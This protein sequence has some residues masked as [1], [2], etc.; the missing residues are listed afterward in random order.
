MA[1][2]L[3]AGGQARQ[4]RERDE[5]AQEHQ[6]GDR[7][8]SGGCEVQDQCRAFCI[9]SSCLRTPATRMGA[10]GFPEVRGGRSPVCRALRHSPR[11]RSGPDI[12]GPRCRSHRQQPTRYRAHSWTPNP[13]PLT[14]PAGPRHGAVLPGAGSMARPVPREFRRRRS[15]SN[16]VL[17]LAGPPPPSACL[18]ERVPA[19]SDCR[20]RRIPRSSVPGRPARF[21]LNPADKDPSGLGRPGRPG[22]A[23]PAKAGSGPASGAGTGCP[24]RTFIGCRKQE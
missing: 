20:A 1:E 8:G 16:K 5:L 10:A 17:V 4:S 9:Q 11:S 3:H 14:L 23:F 24:C 6:H 2:Q 13:I 18:P 15:P 22:V 12:T 19:R 21:S 7:D